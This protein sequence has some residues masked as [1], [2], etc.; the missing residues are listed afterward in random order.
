MGVGAVT[1]QKGKGAEHDALAGACL[2]GDGDETV[3]ELYVALL[4]K[5]V[6]FYVEGFKQVEES[7]SYQIYGVRILTANTIRLAIIIIPIAMIIGVVIISLPLFFFQS[8]ES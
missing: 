2:A 1:E 8:L 7:F 5:S 6:V 3:V 4:D